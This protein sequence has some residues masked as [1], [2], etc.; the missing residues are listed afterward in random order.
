MRVQ[1][2]LNDDSFTFFGALFHL[3]LTFDNNNSLWFSTNWRG[4]Q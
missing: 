1:S 3:S 4:R 2:K